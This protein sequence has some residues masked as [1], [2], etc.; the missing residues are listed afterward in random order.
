MPEMARSMRAAAYAAVVVLVYAMSSTVQAGPVTIDDGQIKVSVRRGEPPAS[1]PSMS[2]DAEFGTGMLSVQDNVLP[3]NI[4]TV[5]Y[6]LSQTGFIIDSTLEIDTRKGSLARSFDTGM[7]FIKFTVTQNGTYDLSGYISA[8]NHA[9][10]T[11]KVV[12]WDVTAGTQELFSNEQVSI[13][14]PDEVLTLGE[15]GGDSTNTLSGSLTG[16]LIAGHSYSFFYE[17]EIINSNNTTHLASSTSATSNITLALTVPSPAAA[18]LGLPLLGMLG[19]SRP[20]R[21]RSF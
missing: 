7:N 6:D 13:N 16:S 8:T 21:R 5:E 9:K 4:A 11:L 15:T 19:M 14:T 18:G 3:S 17:T 12:L 2:T 10:V 20:R 1:T